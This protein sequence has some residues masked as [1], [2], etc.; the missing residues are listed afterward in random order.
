M[1]FY[2]VPLQRILKMIWGI[3]LLFF[4]YSPHLKFVETC[5]YGDT[6][7]IKCTFVYDLSV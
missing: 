2:V 4:K 6:Y 1:V 5:H 7:F 3:I